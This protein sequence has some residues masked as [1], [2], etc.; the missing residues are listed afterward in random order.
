MDGKVEVHK[1]N[2]NI[3][4]GGVQMLKDMVTEQFAL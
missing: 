2:P 4:V 1:Q 3:G